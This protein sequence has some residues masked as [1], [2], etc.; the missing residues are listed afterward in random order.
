V[1]RPALF[2]VCRR[3]AVAALVI[4]TCSFHVAPVA[5][6]PKTE[7]CQGANANDGKDDAAAINRC[8]A[9]N[10]SRIVLTP[11]TYDIGSSLRLTRDNIVFTGELSPS[12]GAPVLRARPALV[13]A[14]LVVDNA[15]D[16]WELSNLVFDG[17]RSNRLNKSACS[18]Y[19][20][21]YTNIQARGTLW[22]IHDI[23]SNNTLCGTGIEVKGSNY[24]IR[25]SQFRSNGAQPGP[26]EG[27]EP[28]S[29]GIT[30]LN[31]DG[32]QVFGNTL[33]DNTDVD[34]I[35]GGSSTC[36]IEMNAVSHTATYGFAGLMVGYFN[37]GFA[38]LHAGTELRN[39][40]VSSSLD[41][42]G[43]GIMDGM[44]PWDASITIE[45]GQVYNNTA[46]GAVH[47]LAVDGV[48]NGNVHDNTMSG[49]QGSRGLRCSQP[50]DYTA[51]HAGSATLQ[52]GLSST[53]TTIWRAERQLRSDAS[54]QV[55]V[56]SR[57][58]EA[59]RTRSQE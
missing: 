23:Q 16:G 40:T 19:R 25:N 52:A 14:I 39:N 8:L 37:E 18:G 54:Y 5:A 29:D 1:P 22:T 47:N 56:I 3:T 51:A 7:R 36:V 43:F 4:V 10:P 46:T 48:S 11:G 6:A 12:G 26:G 32:G 44:H 2:A 35:V 49:A 31:C 27:P 17:N 9:T 34:L 59:R 20:G 42:L 30:L 38:G 53:S 41:M 21:A 13:G 55:L 15:A 33:V 58:T 24:V 45:G 28:W 57:P 50:F